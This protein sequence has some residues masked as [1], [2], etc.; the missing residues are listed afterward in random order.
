MRRKLLLLAFLLAVLLPLRGAAQDKFQYFRHY[1]FSGGGNW[2]TS[3][4]TMPDNECTDINNMI[5]TED[6]AL[7][8]RNGY[9]LHSFVVGEQD[10]AYLPKSIFRFYPTGADND[11]QWLLH[12]GSK[13]W[14]YNAFSE[15]WEEIGSGMSE[16]ESTWAA[17]M[18]AAFITNDVDGLL[19]WDGSTLTNMSQNYGAPRC[20][21]IET[22][23]NRVFLSG[24]TENPLTVYYSDLLNA[25]LWPGAE[26][27]TSLAGVRAGYWTVQSRDNGI[28]SGLKAWRDYLAIFT[29]NTI[30]LLQGAYPSEVSIQQLSGN[31]GCTAPRS[32]T[33]ARQDVFF[34]SNN[35]LYTLGDPPEIVSLK[36]GTQLSNATNCVGLSYKRYFMMSDGGSDNFMSST[37]SVWVFDMDKRNWTRFDDMP[38]G[39]AYVA[40]GVNDNSVFLFGDTERERIYEWDE[41][42]FTDALG[43]NDRSYPTYN[44]QYPAWYQTK[45]F[46]M[47]SPE[48]FKKFRTL[49]ADTFASSGDFSIYYY[50]DYDRIQ[51][52]FDYLLTTGGLLDVFI[53]DEGYLDTSSNSV[54]NKPF[55]TGDGGKFIQ[56]KFYNLAAEQTIKFY[57]FSLRWL[58]KHFRGGI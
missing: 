51:G 46:A 18:G 36:L 56:F 9:Q 13:L 28:I 29:P 3:A 30:H 1:D 24:S 40:T 37:D 27:A 14:V 47:G 49:Q 50:I 12:A 4:F 38:I 33:S 8:K 7:E 48:H 10:F 16:R 2:S 20:Q 31:I 44:G 21:Y 39:C 42:Y 25:S 19:K 58:Q 45:Q 43:R 11:P 52:A 32:I 6:G 23:Q 5:V 35:H 55:N 22:Y 34:K 26:D 57:G 41:D 53:L 54:V 15:A 17:F